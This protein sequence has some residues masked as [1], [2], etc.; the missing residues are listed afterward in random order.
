MVNPEGQEIKDHQFKARP[1]NAKIFEKAS[2]G[3]LPSVEKKQA[4]TFTEF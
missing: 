2:V 4:T 1:Y 3:K